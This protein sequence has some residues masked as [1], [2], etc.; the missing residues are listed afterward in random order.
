M[1][2][3]NAEQLLNAVMQDEKNVQ[4][5]SSQ[6][7]YFLDNKEVLVRIN[8]ILGKDKERKENIFIIDSDVIKLK[9]SHINEYENVIE[10]LHGYSLGIFNS[11]IT[12]VTRTAM[13]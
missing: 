2:K 12:D 3:E 10:K 11:M 7:E 13:K 4:L 8:A 1:S 6:A 5:S 9:Q